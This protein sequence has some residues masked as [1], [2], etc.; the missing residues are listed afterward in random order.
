MEQRWTSDGAV[1]EEERRKSGLTTEVERRR[2]G[3]ETLAIPQHKLLLQNKPS[4]FI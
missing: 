1:T 2:N 3:G 4:G